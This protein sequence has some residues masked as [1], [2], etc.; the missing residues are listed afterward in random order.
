MASRRERRGI[1]WISC[2]MFTDPRSAWIWT[3]LTGLK[4]T[5][6][7]TSSSHLTSHPLSHSLSPFSSSAPPGACDLLL[8]LPSDIQEVC[9]SC[10]TSL[11][12]DVCLSCCF[13][14]LQASRRCR[15][16]GDGPFSQP[17][18][19]SLGRELWGRLWW[20]TRIQRKSHSD[21]SLSCQWR[22]VRVTVIL[23]LLLQLL[24][25]Y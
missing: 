1:K 7:V 5:S 21:K 11:P 16:D 8:H 25:Y 22:Q 12:Q 6:T 13:D 10:L 20:R 14:G 2:L 24:Y 9:L 4:V 17:R 3:R 15:G 23:L 18:P 19:F